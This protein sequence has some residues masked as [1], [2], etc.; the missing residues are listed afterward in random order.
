MISS[1]RIG[2]LAVVLILL[3]LS[4]CLLPLIAAEELQVLADGEEHM[5]YETALFDTSEVI[6]VDI[7]MDRDAWQAMLDDALSETYY[8]CDVTINGTTF[9]S[10]G[11]RPKGNTSLSS[12]ARDPDDN[13][14]SFKLEFDQ[15]VDGQNCFGLDKLVLNNNYA[16]ASGMKEA[17]VYDMYQYLKAD[18]PLYNY[19]E[20]SVNGEY[21]GVY[22]ALEAVEESFLLRNYGSTAGKLYKPEGMHQKNSSGANLNY[23]DDDLNS[24]STIWE[25]A[26]TDSDDADHRRV[27]EAL[28]QLYT[29]E[30]L[31]SCLDV[32]NVLKY[33][34]VHNFAVNEDS[35]SGAMAHNYYLLEQNG[36]LNMIPWDYNLS[37]GGMRGGDATD[38][39]NE[40][41]DDS[42]SSTEFFDALLENEEYLARYH[43]YYK[44]LTDEYF[45]GGVFEETWQRIHNQIDSLVE[46]DPNL[47]YTYEEYCIA[48]ETLHEVIRLRTESVKGQLNGTIPSTSEGQ[49]QN[50]EL[51]VDA[52]SINLSD[53]GTFMGGMD[54]G[55]F[56]EMPKPD[57]N[58]GEMMGFPEMQNMPPENKNMP[59]E[60]HAEEGKMPPQ[61]PENMQTNRMPKNMTVESTTENSAEQYGL[62]VISMLLLAAGFVFVCF[63]KR[64]NY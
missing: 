24:Y 15:F 62:L 1:K 32:D 41:I 58:E 2:V 40:P 49:K 56:S 7:S 42:Y 57:W 25:G 37:F 21:W 4:V 27:V 51:L 35:L 19:A 63:Y 45:D 31:E 46:R 5:E 12:V 8:Q 11:I 60:R 61:M 38:V 64:K 3:A 22:L 17:V 28:K 16:D 20:I 54:G 14:Y 53:M 36:R 39:V 13:R 34:A 55:A 23:T 52:S 43:Q 10:V 33:M 26:V 59:A 50:A 6:A 48:S 9:Y 29:G 47:Q 44:M 18:A 30:N